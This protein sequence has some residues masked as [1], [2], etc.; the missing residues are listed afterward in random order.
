MTGMG[1]LDDHL[2]ELRRFTLSAD[3]WTLVEQAEPGTEDLLERLIDRF[4][5]LGAEPVGELPENL[6]AV[7]ESALM[8]ITQNLPVPGNLSVSNPAFHRDLQEFRAGLDRAWTTW[9]NECRQ[10]VRAEQTD[11]AAQ[12]NAL[13]ENARLA[14][15]ARESAEKITEELRTL[16]STA[17]AL[18]LASH[19]S[20]RAQGHRRNARVAIAVVIGLSVLLIAGGWLLIHTIPEPEAATNW[21]KFARDGLARAFAIAGVSYGIAFTARIYRTNSH[22][23]AVYEQKAAALQTFR[24]F[25]ESSD[26]PD[27]RVLILGELVRAVFAPSGTGVFEKDAERTVVE[28]AAPLAAV[29]ARSSMRQG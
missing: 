18:E 22:L 23:A 14:R 24:L 21:G 19:Y 29:L 15:A 16:A 12:K 7:A 6:V 11:A 13:E 4:A 10:H 25:T 27:S 2:A 28:S 3:T 1:F 5:M 17:G 20:Q 26:D 8:S 9:R